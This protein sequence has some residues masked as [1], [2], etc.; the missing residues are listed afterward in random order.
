VLID[1][2]QIVGNNTAGF[3]YGWEGGGTK[4]KETH[5]L[6]VS[7][8]YV[9][10]NF[11]PGLWTD[12]DNIDSLIETNTVENNSYIG[13]FHEISYAAVIRDN[14]V[15]GNG[16]DY[17]VDLW[18]AGITVAA[19]SD[20]EVTGNVLAGNAGGIV[21]IQQNRDDAPASFGPV[22]VN[23]LFVHNNQIEL[24]GGFVGLRQEVGDDSYYTSRNNRFESNTV[25]AEGSQFYWNNRAMSEAEWNEFGL[26]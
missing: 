11:G 8:N 7:D 15:T 24:A 1:S 20:V 9:A 22:E 23:N 4:F 25:V 12:I 17:T 6:V 18:G 14:I 21:A 5:R 3:R 19:S 2:N 13:I 10:N 16:F 26:S